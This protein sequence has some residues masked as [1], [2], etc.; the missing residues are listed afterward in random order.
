MNSVSIQLTRIS[1]TF[2]LH[3]Y[4]LLKKKTIW[5]FHRYNITSTA[6]VNLLPD[7]PKIVRITHDFVLIDLNYKCKSTE[8][9]NII[10][11]QTKNQLTEPFYK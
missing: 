11:F 8:E 10:T 5:I 7:D 1:F 4:V 9:K 2:R 6:V 3:G